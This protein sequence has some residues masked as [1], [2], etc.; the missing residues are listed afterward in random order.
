V[1]SSHSSAKKRSTA[2]KQLLW[3]ASIVTGPRQRARPDFHLK[4]F[5][6]C[7]A[8]GRPLTASWSKGRNGNYAYYHCW[9]VPSRERYQS[10]ARRVFVDELKELQPTPDSMRLVK[11]HVLRAWEQRKAEPW[12]PLHSDHDQSCRSPAAYALVEVSR[13]LT[14]RS[15]SHETAGK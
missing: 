4:G 1:I 14:D 15:R 8:C 11:E 2:F 3:G 12:R 6:R 5:V 13:G 9:R 7:E 10:E